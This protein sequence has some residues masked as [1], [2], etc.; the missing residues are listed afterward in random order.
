MRF[1]LQNSKSSTGITAAS[2]SNLSPRDEIYIDDERLE[3]SGRGGVS[4]KQK[5]NKILCFTFKKVL[6]KS[7]ENEDL[8]KFFF[9]T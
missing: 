6:K 3:G 8:K 1:C 9:F 7:K 4:F 2:S 5:K